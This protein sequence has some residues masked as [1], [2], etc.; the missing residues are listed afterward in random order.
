MKVESK[1]KVESDDLVDDIGKKCI[2]LSRQFLG[3][4]SATVTV[5]LKWSQGVSPE[6]T[7]K[8]IKDHYG[9][10]KLV[11]DVKVAVSR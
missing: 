11:G 7:V 8:L 1:M 10:D 2:E 9:K 5:T 6:K 4:D 3:T